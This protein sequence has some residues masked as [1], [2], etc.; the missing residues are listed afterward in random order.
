VLQGVEAVYLAYAPDLAAPG[1]A[2]RIRDFSLQA[3]QS[4]VRRLVLLSGRG[5]PQA[6]V[7]EAGV[8]ESGAELTVLR[9]AWFC[10]NFS[11]G[12]LHEPLLQG[13]LAFPAGDVQEPFV[14]AED[15]ADVAV[16]AL[17]EEGHAG[18]TYELT[19]PRLLGFAQAVA[20]I[21]E[22]SGRPLR[23]VPITPAQYADALAPYLPAQEAAFL[24][25]LFGQVLDGHNAH[26][27]DGVQRALGRPPRDF[28]EYAR[29]AAARGAWTQRA[30]G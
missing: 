11:E 13:E 22:A 7:S 28:R 25:E 29:E 14:D 17:T 27:G 15:I 6:Q 16:A 8:R 3:V 24:G 10:Q 19:G 1:A 23:Y 20:E 26:L 9:A 5:E 12:H 21:S 30:T 2:E 4:G 18:H